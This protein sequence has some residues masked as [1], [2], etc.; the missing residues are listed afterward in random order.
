MIVKPNSMRTDALVVPKS[1]NKSL[2]MLLSLNTLRA[3]AAIAE[4]WVIIG[5]DQA[6]NKYAKGM[7]TGGISVHTELCMALMPHHNRNI[8]YVS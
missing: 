1:S 2:E 3:I 6:L 8:I 5:E 4:L 7:T